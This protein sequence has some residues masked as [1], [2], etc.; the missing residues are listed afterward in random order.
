MRFE[1]STGL[2]IIMVYEAIHASPLRSVP[3]MIQQNSRCISVL[4]SFNA[5]LLGSMTRE[6]ILTFISLRSSL[7]TE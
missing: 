2:Q 4:M 1:H 7:D 5:R 3:D 6:L